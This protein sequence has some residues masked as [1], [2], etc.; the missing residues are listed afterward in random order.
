M[1]FGLRGSRESAADTA[2][3]DLTTTDFAASLVRRLGA[4]TVTFSPVGYEATPVGQ[5]GWAAYATGGYDASVANGIALLQK[6]LA[7]FTADCPASYDALVGYSQGQQVVRETYRGLP[8]AAKARIAFIVGYGD[9]L[10]SGAQK[11]INRGQ[12]TPGLAGVAI[13][14]DRAL[15]IPVPDYRIPARFV[16]RV[17]DWCRHGDPVCNFSAGNLA[18]YKFSQH[19]L[20]AGSNYISQAAQAAAQTYRGLPRLPG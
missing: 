11:A 13:A 1:L 8:P 12:P 18:R 6:R 5:G 15:H 9:P 10:F 20:Y 19:V 17:Q 14:A 16:P 2:V 4:R 7:D 3:S